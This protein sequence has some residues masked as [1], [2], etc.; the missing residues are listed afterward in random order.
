MKK[1]I[2]T[3]LILAILSSGAGALRTF[4]QEEIKKPH[5]KEAVEQL[6]QAYTQIEEDGVDLSKYIAKSVEPFTTQRVKQQANI[7]Q[8]KDNTI[9]LAKEAV[10]NRDKVVEEAINTLE[11][12]ATNPHKVAEQ[13]QGQLAN[14]KAKVLHEEEIPY[15]SKIEYDPNLSVGET[16]LAQK[17]Q[18]GHFKV[19][20]IFLGE[21]LIDKKEELTPAKD[22]VVIHGTKVPTQAHGTHVSSQIVEDGTT[23]DII[24]SGIMSESERVKANARYIQG[25]DFQ[26]TDSLYQGP[27]SAQNYLYRQDFNLYDQYYGV[28]SVF[29]NG[30]IYYAEVM[31]GVGKMFAD[32][33]I[34]ETV[35]LDGKEYLVKAIEYPFT[36]QGYGPHNYIPAYTDPHGVYHPEE[37]TRSLWKHNNYIQSHYYTPT[38]K[39][40][41]VCADPRMLSGNGTGV[42]TN[43][44]IILDLNDGMV[45]GKGN[46]Y[47]FPSS[48]FQPALSGVRF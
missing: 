39:M 28:S 18:S 11:E 27:H 32:L 40:V 4:H 22:E 47:S 24:S 3:G 16:R 5:H 34:G 38:A 14:T 46:V 37:N 42:F 7:E 48:G 33:Q 20:G 29:N 36:A 12:V 8:V 30:N 1:Y 21:E 23:F 31:T 15:E 9:T 13:V 45:Y 26:I 25:E 6:S 10:V 41:Q 17:G 44:I 19:T 35:I 43:K 2:T